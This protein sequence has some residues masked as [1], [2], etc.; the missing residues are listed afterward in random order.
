[1]GTGET[2]P[3]RDPPA[4]TQVLIASERTRVTRVF[5]PGRT[6]I[7]KEPLGSDAQR[8][9][10]HELAMLERLRGATGLAQ[11]ADVPPH[12]GS[13][14]LADAGPRSALQL[15]KPMAV[16][17]L[18]GLAV[19]LAR[20][21]AE[22]HHRGV[23][24]RDIAPANIVVSR[25][26]APCLVDFALAT[27]LAEVR[28]DFT[29]HSEIVGTL[30][31]LAPEQTGRTGW[32]VDERADLYALGATLYELATGQPPFGSGDPLRL[33][34]DHLARVPVPPAN[35]NPAVPATFSEIVMHLLEKEPDNRYQSADGLV[36][37]LEAVRHASAGPADAAFR[38]AER[39][40]PLRLLAPSELVGRDAEVATLRDAFEEALAGG[41]RGVLI[42]GPPGV[43]KT[44]L[45]AEARAIVASSG[46]W[47]VA[48]KFDKHRRDL[49]FDGTQPRA[50]GRRHAARGSGE[51]SGPGRDDRTAHT[52]E[53]V[54]HR[55]AS[56]HAP[57][58]RPAEAD[59]RRLALGRR[60]CSWPPATVRGH[61]AARIARRG[62]GAAVPADGRGDGVTGR[63]SGAHPPAG[64]DRRTDRGGG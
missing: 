25:D 3:D 7:R 29:H 42:S 58:R 14:M 20:A 60:G 9:L 43:G 1:M 53:S 6:A 15:S 2:A 57:P 26:G 62:I 21:V 23:M 63:T 27:L 52:R 45:A 59:S 31:Y 19:D 47:F 55:R 51:G 35:V 37:D 48:G 4:R 61:R 33:V 36:R 40:V 28:P 56:R 44:A 5:L 17:D 34:H 11:L 64:R 54:R 22:M 50:D 30:E 39:D 46:G 49:E 24:H 8:R 16:D 38:I 32:S 41:C 12:P 13:I 18:V 10:Q